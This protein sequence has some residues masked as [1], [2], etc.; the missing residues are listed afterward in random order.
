MTK[1]LVVQIGKPGGEFEL[2]EREIQAPGAGEVRVKV[3]ACGIC[4]SDHLVKDG[5]WPGLTY[6]R[7]PG[8][9]VTGVIDALG[10]GITT[11]KRGER[12]GVGWHG[13]HCFVCASCRRG[14]FITCEKSQ[15]TGFTHDG[16][17][18]QYMIARLC[19]ARASPHSMRCA[20]AVPARVTWSR[21][22]ASGDLGT[23][24]SSTPRSS[25]IALLASAAGP[26]TPSWRNG[27]ERSL[28][29]TA[30][31]PTLRRSCGSS[32]ARR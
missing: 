20:T 1:N 18:Q 19:C 16:G 25:A 8:H 31:R 30:R 26:R 28:I 15:I 9:E 32:A 5:L 17:Y 2:V 6:P 29:L 3:A 23:S 13:G 7:V 4:Y 22:R 21:S 11:W 10:P 12:V 14:E 24:A 27:L